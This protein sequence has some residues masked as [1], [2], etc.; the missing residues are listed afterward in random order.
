[1][2]ANST[3]QGPRILVAVD[4]SEPSKWA[5]VTASR[6]ANQLSAQV[7]LVNVIDPEDRVTENAVTAQQ[8][9][10]AH[11]AKGMAVLEQARAVFGSGTNVDAIQRIGSPATEIEQV[12]LSWR[13]DFIVMGTRGRGRFTQLVLGSTAEKVIRQSKCPVVTVAHEPKPVSTSPSK[14]S[15][16]GVSEPSRLSAA[17]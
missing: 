16:T 1:M 15:E 11:Q 9:D 3:S 2:A 10:A 8:R 17:I 6:L 5:V 12:A 14:E 13:A 7:R 4:G